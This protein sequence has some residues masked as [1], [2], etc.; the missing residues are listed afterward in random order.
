[1]NPQASLARTYRWALVVDE[2]ELRRMVDECQRALA[3]DGVDPATIGLHFEM[4]FSDGLSVTTDSIDAVVAEENPHHRSIVGISID[5]D[6]RSDRITCRIGTEK[7]QQTS[8][9]VTGPD[10]NWVHVTFS[11]IEERL[12]LMKQWH[13]RPDTLRL[14]MVPAGMAFGIALWITATKRYP[15]QLVVVGANGQPATTHLGTVILLSL[16]A[17]VVAA[18]SPSRLDLPSR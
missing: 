9:T 6:I 14:A 4:K 10:R 5:G 8:I 13:A 18:R 15:G 2:Q 16:I 7:T 12:R 1:M 3:K 17:F 11:K